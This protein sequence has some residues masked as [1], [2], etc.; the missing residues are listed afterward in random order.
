AR[1]DDPDATR[2]SVAAVTLYGGGVQA[3]AGDAQADNGAKQV[4]SAERAVRGRLTR[5]LDLDWLRQQKALV[6]SGEPEASRLYQLM[7]SRHMP[8]DVFHER[9]RGDAPDAFGLEAVREWIAGLA[10]EPVT[11]CG[12][13]GKSLDVARRREALA[14]WLSGPLLALGERNRLAVVHLSGRNLCDFGQSR[15]DLVSHALDVISLRAGV[16]RDLL[17]AL[18]IPGV[19]H[20]VGVV[21]DE[22]M[23]QGPQWADLMDQTGDAAVTLQALGLVIENGPPVV[24]LATLSHANDD[25]RLQSGVVDAGPVSLNTTA[26]SNLGS[27]L[28]QTPG[29]AGTSS[30]LLPE[31]L[32]LHVRGSRHQT[33]DELVLDVTTT[34]DCRLTLV[35]IEPNGRATVL[36]PNQFAKDNKLKSDQPLTVPDPNGPFLLSLDDIGRETFVAICLMEDRQSLPG[37]VHDFDIQPFT[38]LGD[39]RS[40]VRRQLDADRRERV[41]VGRRLSRRKRRSLRRQG[42]IRRRSKQPLKQMRAAVSVDVSPAPR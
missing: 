28:A 24:D 41:L 40:H 11:P 10:V 16:S 37:I 36:F 1:A 20:A 38:I 17:N 31:G 9:K 35:N 7:V 12:E 33:G 21:V 15:A 34:R 13:R 4:S 27:V 22:D 5:I 25:G 8:Y 32:T 19:K 30:D 3:G 14:R 42:I 26:S 29:D 2:K 18:A 39:W 23:Q 6:R